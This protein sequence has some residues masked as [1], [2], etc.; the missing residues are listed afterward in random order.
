[1]RGFK[2][3]SFKDFSNCCSVSD[4][5]AD[6]IKRCYHSEY[7]RDGQ[8]C[9]PSTCPRWHKLCRAELSE[10][11]ITVRAKRPMQ[12]PQAVIADIIDREYCGFGVEK[13]YKLAGGVL[14]ALRQRTAMR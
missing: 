7:K 11:K 12:Q 2:I 6:G 8:I 9:A 14:K 5:T 4:I 10:E 3:V 1:M 13:N